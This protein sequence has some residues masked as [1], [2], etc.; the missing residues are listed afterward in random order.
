M[1]PLSE[2]GSDGPLGDCQMLAVK[3]A[4]SHQGWSMPWV[5]G[6]HT[7]GLAGTRLPGG[8]C[9]DWGSRRW[10]QTLTSVCLRPGHQLLISLHLGR[11]EAQEQNCIW[12]LLIRNVF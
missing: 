11:S 12:R 6:T 3:G 4:S 9:G 10:L 7:W 5:P 8:T 2:T 1:F